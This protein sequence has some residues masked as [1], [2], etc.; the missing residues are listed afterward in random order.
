MEER[1]ES[2]DWLDEFDAFIAHPAPAFQCFTA[3]DYHRLN[4]DLETEGAACVVRIEHRVGPAAAGTA[5]KR[6]AAMD[7]PGTLDVVRFLARHNGVHLFA[8]THPEYYPEGWRKLEAGVEIFR[9][10]EWDARTKENRAEWL[11]KLANAELPYGPDDFIAIGHPRG[12]WNYFHW[13]T[14]GPCAGRVFW[15][16]WTM[17]PESAD[18]CFAVSFE[19]FISMLHANPS[20]LLNEVLCGYSRYFDRRG[21]TQWVALNYSED[22]GKWTKSPYAPSEW[23]ML[24][25]FAWM[26]VR[27]SGLISTW[28]WLILGT[29]YAILQAMVLVRVIRLH[30]LQRVENLWSWF[31]FRGAII[32][33]SLGAAARSLVTLLGHP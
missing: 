26:S 11:E 1:A 10:E 9:V 2:T 30:R 18:D 7:V 13:V 33:V 23:M 16:P 25:I 5:L 8:P 27:R 28:L 24:A 14:R 31:G 29:S 19:E 32:A 21:K 20:V 22:A 15:W 3:S 12:S 6:I 4:E 17:P